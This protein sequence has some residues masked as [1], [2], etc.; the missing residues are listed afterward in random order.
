MI[1]ASE[2]L[3]DY[4]ARFGEQSST[5]YTIRTFYILQKTFYHGFPLSVKCYNSQVPREL[6]G[7]CPHRDL[8][9]GLYGVTQRV[10]AEML[11]RRT[12]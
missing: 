11:P 10:V 8:L 12:W 2:Q 3:A 5:D 6:T 1:C 9:K 4:Q 7:D